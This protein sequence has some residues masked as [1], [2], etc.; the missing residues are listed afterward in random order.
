MG[1]YPARD[2]A[3]LLFNTAILCLIT[4]GF[5]RF[6]QEALENIAEMLKFH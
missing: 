1:H 4:A 6:L 5:Q 2:N 3:P